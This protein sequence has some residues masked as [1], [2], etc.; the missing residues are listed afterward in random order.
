MSACRN[1]LPVLRFWVPIFFAFLFAPV[2]L[3]NTAPVLIPALVSSIQAGSLYRYDVAATDLEGDPITYSIQGILPGWLSF[4][5]PTIRGVAANSDV[6]SHTFT[7]R[8]S[9]SPGGLF[10]DQTVTLEVTFNSDLDSD[11]DGMPDGYEL[12]NGFDPDPNNPGARYDGGD[13]ADGDGLTNL[14]E[15]I[16]GSNPRVD[17]QGPVITVPPEFTVNPFGLYTQVDSGTAT[18]VDGL[19]DNVAVNSSGRLSHY[20]PGRHS[21]LWTSTDSEGNKATPKSQTFNVRPF[22][23]FGNDVV[24]VEGGVGRVKVLLNGIAPTYPV[25]ITYRVSGTLGSAEHDLGV[26]GT[27]TINEP[28][29]EGYIQFSAFDDGIEEPVETV[30]LTL[31]AAGNAI[32]GANDDVSIFIHEGNVTPRLSLAATQ[33]GNVVRTVAQTDGDVNVSA[34]IFDANIDDTHTFNWAGTVNALTDA[35]SQDETFSFDPSLV[36]PGVYVLRADVCDQLNSCGDA[37][38]SITVV[39]TLS[40]LSSSLD[41]DGDGLLDSLDGY[42]DDDS[43]GVPNHLDGLNL[44]NV[45]QA[46][47]GDEPGQYQLESDAG[48]VL[49]LGSVAVK[50]EGS[51]AKITMLD[52]ADY[53]NNS[54]AVADSEYEYNDGLYDFR[55]EELSSDGQAVKL[56]IPLSVVIPDSAI[57]RQLTVAG[58]GDFVSDA[59]NSLASAIGEDGYCPPPGDARYSSGLTA[60]DWC[61]QLTIKEGGSN[62]ADGKANGRIASLGGVTQRIVVASKDKDKGSG[63]LAPY[64]LLLLSLMI[65]HRRFSRSVV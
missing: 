17:D 32:V 12:D 41:T 30:V 9:D 29:L 33:V 50:V 42:G 59:S 38:L 37:E 53:G 27:A 14:E 54:Q 58:W 18:A 13:D 10:D 5:S 56:V 63:A 40:P 6:G 24:V 23:E 57:Y 35:D 51:Q 4:N 3:A 19:E 44:A 45:L 7:I 11:G 1:K 61:L 21:I 25:T 48:S 31:T 39:E 65:L 60:G 62:D 26:S 2:V 20:R 16:A 22:V 64:G 8:A 28:N 15:Y 49:R 55:I 36:I 34:T 47:L 43:D 46:S 52:A